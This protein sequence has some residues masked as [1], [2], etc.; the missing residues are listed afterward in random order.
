MLR[1]L[2]IPGAWDI[3][4][5][6]HLARFSKKHPFVEW[7]LQIKSPLQAEAHYPTIDW[8]EE[9]AERA[10]ED[11]RIALHLEGDLGRTGVC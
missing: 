5:T 7:G 3:Q 9:L 8:M 10:D 4:D 1:V 6:G 11:T 2:T